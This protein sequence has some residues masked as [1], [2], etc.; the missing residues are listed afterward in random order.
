MEAAMNE[1][2]NIA[3][4][5]EEGAASEN[6]YLK[7]SASDVRSIGVSIFIQMSREETRWPL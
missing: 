4:R 6:Y 2:V 7:F 3:R 5:V 1:A